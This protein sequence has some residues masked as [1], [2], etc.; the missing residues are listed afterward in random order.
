MM[1]TKKSKRHYWANHI[2]DWKASGETQSHYCRHHDLKPHQLTYWKQVFKSQPQTA[3]ASSSNGFVTLKVTDTATPD[4]TLHLPNGL[5][6]D[7]IHA[8]NLAVIREI[9]GWQR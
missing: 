9:I 4:V 3:Q 5:R 1:N 7:G 6:V 8:G 2:K